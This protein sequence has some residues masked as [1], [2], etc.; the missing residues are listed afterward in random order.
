[1]HATDT[2]HYVQTALSAPLS[3]RKQQTRFFQPRHAAALMANGCLAIC[4]P[5]QPMAV[6]WITGR[7]GSM[8]FDR[9]QPASQR[10]F[11]NGLTD[12]MTVFAL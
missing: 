4:A 9:I 1:M 7:D 6:A 2:A 11:L 3:L 5:S 8:H 10:D 12:S